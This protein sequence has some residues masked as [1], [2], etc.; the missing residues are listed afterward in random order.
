MSPTPE[1]LEKFWHLRN[2]LLLMR[3]ALGYRWSAHDDSARLEYELFI[4]EVR[5]ELARYPEHWEWQYPPPEGWVVR[6]V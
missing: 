2:R 1:N 4:G 6:P 3:A 5:M